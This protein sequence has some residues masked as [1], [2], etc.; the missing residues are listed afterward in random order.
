MALVVDG[1]EPSEIASLLGRSP[2]AVR[3]NLREART[4]LRQALEEDQV[5][6]QV[7]ESMRKES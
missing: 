3:Q 2:D 5:T 6:H 7:A 1:L 4:R